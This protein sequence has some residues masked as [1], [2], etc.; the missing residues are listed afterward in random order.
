MRCVC[1]KSSS[2]LVGANLFSCCTSREVHDKRHREIATLVQSILRID[3]LQSTVSPAFNR[4]Q[5]TTSWAESS[6]TQDDGSNAD[7]P[8]LD[9]WEESADLSI[10]DDAAPATP[11]AAHAALA[12]KKAQ[13]AMRKIARN[14]MKFDHIMTEDVSRVDAA[15]H[16]IGGDSVDPLANSAIEANIA[17]NSNTFRYSSLRQ[18]VHTKKVLKNNGPGKVDQAEVQAQEAAQMA[19]ILQRLGVSTNVLHN[20]R[21]R[22]GLLSKLHEAIK[23]DLEAVANEDR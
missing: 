22:R 17:F 13:R 16:G 19:I 11:I 15:L 10:E 3:G 4:H 5:R 18:A 20:T 8:L 14:Q 1:T 2:K 23:A 12:S 6:S 9:S 21:E 7:E